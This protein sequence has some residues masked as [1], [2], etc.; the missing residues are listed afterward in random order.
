MEDGVT[1]QL[2]W[3]RQWNKWINSIGKQLYLIINMM[4]E[5]IIRYNKLRP[6][7]GVK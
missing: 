7:S 6:I 4:H 1:E 3:T 5:H 2:L